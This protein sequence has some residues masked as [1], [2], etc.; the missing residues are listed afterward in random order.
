MLRRAALTLLVVSA[1]CRTVPDPAP[2][3]TSA[4]SKPP[5]VAA[6]PAASLPEQ[7]AP[8]TT[9]V[10]PRYAQACDDYL[11]GY[12]EET[13]EGSAEAVSGIDLPQ[14]RRAMVLARC[15]E[16]L[17]SVDAND[18]DLETFAGC[19]GCVGNCI[20]L[21]DCLP[22]PKTPWRVPEGDCGD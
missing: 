8:A 4:V 2:V 20:D 19:R 16:A 12:C 7:A 10:D 11:L 13:D 3:S 18:E 17:E 6:E 15:V 22:D 9:P 1:A 21:V 5:A 14:K